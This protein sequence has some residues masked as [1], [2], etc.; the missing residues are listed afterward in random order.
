[1]K[2]K[3]K[4]ILSMLLVVIMIVG[5]LPISA[6]AASIYDD[7]N[8]GGDY[9]NIISEKEWDIAPGVKEYEQVLNNDAGTRRQVV[10]TAIVD[11]NNPYTKVIAGYKGMEPDENGNFP[12]GYG[13][14]S[15]SVQALEAEKLGYGNVVVATN[16]TLSWYTGDYYKK[17]PHLIGEPLGYTILDGKRFANSSWTFDETTQKYTKHAA[18]GTQTVIVINYDEHPLTGDPRPADIPK[19][20]IRSTTDPLTGWEEQAIPV[21]FTFLVKPDANGN[22]VNQYPNNATHGY[23]GSDIASRTFVGV[24]AD[25]TLVITV[26][27]RHLILPVLRV[28]KWLII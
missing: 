20:W 5:A 2:D 11:L 13:V 3:A 15:T 9:Y 22:P 4:R 24:K 28:T 8:G 10:H 17:N 14:Q 16:T 19:V 18:D 26:S 23:A 6:I 25:G 1:M 21:S 27:D 7:S 12:M